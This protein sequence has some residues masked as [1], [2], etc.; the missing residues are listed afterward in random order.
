MVSD[1]VDGSGR[2]TRLLPSQ[3]SISEI[4]FKPA[5]DERNVPEERLI[6]SSDHFP[7]SALE[8]RA[9][10]ISEEQGDSSIYYQTQPSTLGESLQSGFVHQRW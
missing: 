7:Y 3:T 9:H 8:Y 2:K 10:T 1:Q 6:E 4:L 5:A